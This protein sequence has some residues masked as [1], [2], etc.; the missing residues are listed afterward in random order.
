MASAADGSI[1]R[2]SWDHR[3]HRNPYTVVQDILKKISDD[4]N[5]KKNPSDGVKTASPIKHVIILIGENR[6]LDHTFGVY[7]PKGQ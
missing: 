3:V 6:G 1:G 5:G 2:S 7:K 4:A